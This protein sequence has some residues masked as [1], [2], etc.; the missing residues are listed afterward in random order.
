MRTSCLPYVTAVTLS[1]LA[2]G[3]GRAVSEADAPAESELDAPAEAELDA[4]DWTSEWRQL[5]LPDPRYSERGI[6][7][8][9][10]GWLLVASAGRSSYAYRSSDGVRWIRVRLPDDDARLTGVAYGRGRYV[11]VGHGQDAGPRIWVSTDGETWLALPL[12]EGFGLDGVQF[13]DDRFIGWGI[14]IWSSQDAESWVQSRREELYFPVGA[15]FGAGRYLLVGT[16][17]PQLSTDGLSWSSAPVDCALPTACIA[18]VDEGTPY[19]LFRSV[20]FAAGHFHLNRLRLARWTELA[21]GGRAHAD[22]LPERP[23]P[24]PGLCPTT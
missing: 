10:D 20:L 13:V 7:R 16:G 21:G 22:E 23:L 18:D 2:I 24:A 11:V 5:A 9:P 8:T 17:V 1:A 6:T 3:C 15:A 19:N 12:T 4:D 14:H